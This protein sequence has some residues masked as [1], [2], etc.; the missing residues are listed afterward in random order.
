MGIF[1][2]SYQQAII[3]VARQPID[4]PLAGFREMK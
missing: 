3:D 4:K 2:E 1:G